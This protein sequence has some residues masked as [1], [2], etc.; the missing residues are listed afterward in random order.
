MDLAGYAADE[1][2][3]IKG[4]GAVLTTFGVGELSTI[5]AI[6]GSYA[7]YVPVIHVVGSPSTGSQKDYLLLHHTLGNGDFKVFVSIYKNV[8]IAQ[9]DL[10][11]INTAAAQINA[12]LRECYLK[13]RPV[14]IDLSIDIVTKMMDA[15]PLQ[16]PLDLK[17][18]ENKDELETKATGA[19]LQRLYVAKC[20]ILLGDGCV[21]RHCLTAE[22]RA[23]ITKSNLPTF[24]TPMAKG[25]IDE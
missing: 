13:S 4:V 16:R 20:P 21:A 6:A 7:E 22:V 10:E 9:A 14:Y 11:D 25:T 15:R 3:R 19:L 23:F 8:T 2:A 24:T 5:I 18:S 12:V 1:Y 17:Y